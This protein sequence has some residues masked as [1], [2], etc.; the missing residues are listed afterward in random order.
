M[1]GKFVIKVLSFVGLVYLAGSLVF[2]RA[3]YQVADSWRENWDL[4]PVQQRVWDIPA[5]K[6][7]E[8]NDALKENAFDNPYGRSGRLERP[9]STQLFRRDLIKA[10]SGL[11]REVKD[12][13][14]DYL[15]GVHVVGNLS[16]PG[17]PYVSGLAIPQ[18]TVLGGYDGTSVLIDRV[19][20]DT[21]LVEFGITMGLRPR[22]ANQSV[23]II[24][25]VVKKGEKERMVMLQY[26]LLHEFGHVVDQSE[27]FVLRSDDLPT[28]DLDEC[29][30]A[31]LS[32]KSQRE[33]KQEGVI[34]DI[35]RDFH[36]GRFRDL[37]RSP[38]RLMNALKRS[39][40]E[41]L[42]SISSPAEDFA[43][44]FATYVHAVILGRPWR[45]D[46]FADGSEVDRMTSCH[47]DGRCPKKTAF[48]DRLFNRPATK[49]VAK[50]P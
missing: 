19:Y 18:W 45:L 23:V 3:E 13:L 32:W 1:S 11:P 4:L 30:F 43:E 36:A 16:I 6:L 14:E 20:S 37:R 41:S 44:S 26:L 21:G 12:L 34:A 33:V 38:S 7:G 28:D 40:L 22:S 46:L 39:N 29:G 8:L 42:Y 50:T 48:F 27:K 35:V 2:W 24:P 17:K 10:I 5:D 15:V 49:S 47:L 9:R 31:C 25:R